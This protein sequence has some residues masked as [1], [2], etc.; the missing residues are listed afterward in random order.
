[1]FYLYIFTAPLCIASGNALFKLWAQDSR[2]HLLVGGLVMMV[3][4]NYLIA[5]AIKLT[6]IMQT[7]SIIPILTLTLSL[8]VGYF[9]FHEKLTGIQYLGLC[10]AIIAIALITFPFQMFQK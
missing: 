9:Y 8:S 4:G 6:S 10:F 3:L 2:W 5:N 7:I 1:M